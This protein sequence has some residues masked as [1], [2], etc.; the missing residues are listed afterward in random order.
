MIETGC[1]HRQEL[2]VIGQREERIYS[3]EWCKGTGYGAVNRRIKTYA[4]SKY[5]GLKKR[6]T[7]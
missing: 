1:R 3:K 6:R 5:H 7:R 2:Y 4:E